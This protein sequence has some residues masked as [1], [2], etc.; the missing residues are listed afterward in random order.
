L[1]QR[2]I[3]RLAVY[4]I[5]DILSDEKTMRLLKA[6]CGLNAAGESSNMNND[7]ILRLK[8]TLSA[9]HYYSSIHILIECA[10][11]RPRMYNARG[12]GDPY[13]KSR[14]LTPTSL[15]KQICIFLNM[16]EN[17]LRIKPKLQAPRFT[18]NV[19]KTY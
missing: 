10:L 17:G 14:D 9:R 18:R 11:L 5:A 1:K 16:L 12:D 6:I 15:G 19:C 4:D 2:D 3:S 7:D 8:T 13:D